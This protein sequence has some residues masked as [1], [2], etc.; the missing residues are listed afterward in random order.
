MDALLRVLK[1]EWPN[2]NI[3]EGGIV[4]S[5][6]LIKEEIHIYNDGD[7]L[8]GTLGYRNERVEIEFVTYN[9]YYH[10]GSLIYFLT[11]VVSSTF[12]GVPILISGTAN[13]Y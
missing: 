11:K 9:D 13:C 8:V 10:C 2:Y 1:W 12:T 6:R 5:F 3:E 7:I 4:I